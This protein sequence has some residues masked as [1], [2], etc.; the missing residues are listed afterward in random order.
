MDKKSL[1]AISG[2]IAML[3][4]ENQEASFQPR[5]EPSPSSPWSLYARQESMQYRNL[6][7]RRAI[8]RSK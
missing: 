7:Q 8:T 5:Q 1:A 3:S 6:I 2:V 4:T